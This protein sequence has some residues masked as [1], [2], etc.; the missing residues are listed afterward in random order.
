MWSPPPRFKNREAAIN[1]RVFDGGVVLSYR[2]R[3]AEAALALASGLHVGHLFLLRNEGGAKGV[4]WKIVL[5]APIFLPELAQSLQN[6]I[7]NKLQHNT[8]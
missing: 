7:E 6:I 1:H 2:C 4:R 3:A 8:Y 5:S